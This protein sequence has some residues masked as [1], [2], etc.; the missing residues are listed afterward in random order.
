VS[1]FGSL[2]RL[3]TF[4]YAEVGID[5]FTADA[6]LAG[7]RRFLDPGRGLLSELGRPGRVEGRRAPRYAPLSLAS[8]MRA[9]LPGSRNART[10]QRLPSRL[11]GASPSALSA[12]V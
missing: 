12:P 1:R 5:R 7:Q 2:S 3:A 11:G 8:V 9:D 6:A 10:Q 4:A